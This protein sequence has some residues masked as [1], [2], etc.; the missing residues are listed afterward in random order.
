MAS[1]CRIDVRT[2]KNLF[3]PVKLRHE[4]LE[5]S[6]NSGLLDTGATICHITYPL[7]LRMKLH[8]ACWNNNPQARH[9]RMCENIRDIFK[10]GR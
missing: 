10:M 8:E 4:N 1:I 3:C 7:W 9:E 2:T 6:V 5:L